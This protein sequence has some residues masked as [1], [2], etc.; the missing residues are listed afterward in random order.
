MQ[1]ISSFQTRASWWWHVPFVSVCIA[2]IS[3]FAHVILYY[4]LSRLP[5]GF[6]LRFV[7]FAVYKNAIIF[8][9]LG[10]VLI[11]TIFAYAKGNT[12]LMELLYFCWVP[13]GIVFLLE[14]LVPR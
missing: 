7:L 8:A 12:K 3:E 11:W 14:I 6:A 4:T 2:A 13:L 9:A 10:V 5:V 1:H